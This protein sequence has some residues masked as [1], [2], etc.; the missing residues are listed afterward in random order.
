MRF[1]GTALP[2]SGH[3]HDDP[4]DDP[5]TGLFPGLDSS[6]AITAALRVWNG[7]LCAEVDPEIFFPELGQPATPARSLCA[8]CPVRV[9]CLDVFGDLVHDGVIGGLSSRE[10]RARRVASRQN[11]SAA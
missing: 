10:R 5:P 2:A 8:Q 7:A 9:D 4:L 1:H 6:D 11:G 3:S